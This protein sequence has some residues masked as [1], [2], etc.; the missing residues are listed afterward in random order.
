[1]L[2]DSVRDYA[3]LLL[4][5]E[6]VITFWGGGAR[7][8]AD[9]TPDEA[10]GAHLRLLYPDGGGDDGD[11]DHHLAI[12]ER[13][14]QY[15]GEGHRHRRDETTFWAN[16]T[17]AALRDPGG[18]LQGFAVLIRDL[19]ARRQADAL[20]TS[21]ASAAESAREAAVANLSARMEFLATVSHE[22][23]TPVNAIL[24]YH[25]LLGMRI[26]GSLTAT[27]Q[28][29]LDRASASGRH[30]LSIIDQVLDFARL[31]AERIRVGHKVFHL[32]DVVADALAIV[33]PQAQHRGVEILTSSGAPSRELGAWGDPS[34]ARQIVLNL[35]SNAIKFTDRREGSARLTVSIGVSDDPPPDAE[36]ATEGPWV[37]V[38]VEDTGAGIPPHRLE[39]I[40]EPFVQADMTLTRRHGGT[41]LGLAISRRLARLMRGDLTVRSEVGLGSTFMLWLQQAAT[42]AI[43]APTPDELELDAAEAGAVMPSLESVADAAPQ[44]QGALSEIA[45]ALLDELE[46]VLHAYVR[47]IRTDPRIPSAHDA[48]TSRVEDHLATYIADIAATLSNVQIEDRERADSLEDSSAIQRTIAQK[49]GAQRARLRWSADEVAREFEILEEELVAAVHRGAPRHL[50]APNG[51]AGEEEIERTVALL[52]RFI[53]VAR[54]RSLESHAQ[55]ADTGNSP[56]S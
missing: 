35:L 39:A 4:D 13:E 8:L 22:I 34:R 32:G 31:D 27:Q 36:L 50:R 29:Y 48:E 10:E 40:F 30:L 43:A 24:G 11:A 20:L 33:A 9:W 6:G 3:I 17:I 16:T 2:A 28:N 15:A 52:R 55:S 45:A 26:G 38:R 53:A 47:R 23:R 21:A 56:P 44:R 14:G 46:E 12:A 19:T 5:P 42:E 51:D 7:L 37:F 25:D 1:M 18:A 49:H 54:R 41:G